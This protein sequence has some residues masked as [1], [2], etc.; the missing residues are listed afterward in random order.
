MPEDVMPFKNGEGAGGKKSGPLWSRTT[1]LSLIRIDK[2]AQQTNPSQYIDNW[3]SE[4]KLNGL[5]E[6]TIYSYRQKVE[7]L[8]RQEARIRCLLRHYC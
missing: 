6:T 1:D 7:A 5:V 4:Q 8:P 3:Y 2:Y